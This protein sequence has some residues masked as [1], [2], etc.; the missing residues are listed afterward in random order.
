MLVVD[1]GA[2]NTGWHYTANNGPEVEFETDGMN[3]YHQTV[4][5]LENTV[6]TAVEKLPAVPTEIFFYGAGCDG[7][8]HASVIKNTLKK[9]FPEAKV[10]VH[11]DMLGAAR[12]LFADGDGI[13]CILGTGSNSC[14]YR[15]GEIVKRVPSLGYVL[16]DE[17]S[18]AW[19]G[20][21]LLRKWLL[22]LLPPAIDA[23]LLRKIPDREAEV[24]DCIHKKPLP[25]RWLAE[26]TYIIQAFA[27][28]LVI[29]EII[30]EGF[31]RFVDLKVVPLQ[32]QENIPIGFVGSIALVFQLQLQQVLDRYDC[33]MTEVMSSPLSA[34]VHYH[35]N[36]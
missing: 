25:A 36:R 30:V 33:K 15:K 24:L 19:M 21:N 9:F 29:K 27:E 7:S 8:H 28:H 11:S 4:Q 6:Q 13:V 23:A 14:L 10:E 20:K 22:G 32:Q 12:A 31:Q 3:P 26:H 2:T 16:G 5:E 18:G 35:Q 1:S 34:L 17:G